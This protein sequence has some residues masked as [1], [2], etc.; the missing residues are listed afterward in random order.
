MKATGTVHD[1]CLVKTEQALNLWDED[2]DGKHVL[3]DS[4]M[5][6]QKARDPTC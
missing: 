1:K 3:V 2:V 6:C 5:F 4:D